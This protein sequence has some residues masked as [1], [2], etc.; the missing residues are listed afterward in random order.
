ML[1]LI[2]QTVSPALK[3]SSKGIRHTLDKALLLIPG[4]NTE[5]EA[6]QDATLLSA[7]AA[8]R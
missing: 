7:L 4:V 5:A 2:S 6:R 8:V 1:D 3:T